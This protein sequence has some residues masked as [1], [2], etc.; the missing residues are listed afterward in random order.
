MKSKEVNVTTVPGIV[1]SD[2]NIDF[3]RNNN[4]SY[5]GECSQSS[6]AKKLKIVNT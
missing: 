4:L 6:S 5:G 2:N 1:S 3:E